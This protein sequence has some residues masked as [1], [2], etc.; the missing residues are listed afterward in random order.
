MNPQEQ[1]AEYLPNVAPQPQ[2]H[3]AINHFID[4]IQY[5]CSDEYPTCVN[6]IKKLNYIPYFWWVWGYQIH[7]GI[8]KQLGNRTYTRPI[9]GRG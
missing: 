9:M 3:L 4:M 7:Y 8:K 2:L 1:C 5:M 6:S